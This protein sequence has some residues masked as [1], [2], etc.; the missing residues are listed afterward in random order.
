MRDTRGAA[1]RVRLR[2]Y[3]V[4]RRLMKRIT[5]DAGTHAPLLVGR[6]RTPALA[7]HCSRRLAVRGIRRPY[8]VRARRRGDPGTGPRATRAGTGAGA[9][10]GVAPP[11]R[12]PARR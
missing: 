6:P 4:A 9:P 10:G 12:R 5:R 2:G 3:R 8:G 11:R 1:E 7:R